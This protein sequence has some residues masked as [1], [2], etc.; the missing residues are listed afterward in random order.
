M[1]HIP[2]KAIKQAGDTAEHERNEGATPTLSQRAG[3]IADA[4]RA[5]SGATAAAGAAVI[6]G[7]AAAAAIP[8]LRGRKPGEPKSTP[9]KGRKGR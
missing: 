1:P 7:F 4:A 9:G 8:M 5:H 3:R 6:A 2:H